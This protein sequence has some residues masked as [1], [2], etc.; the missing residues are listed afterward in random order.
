[1]SLS[2]QKFVRRTIEHGELLNRGTS[3]TAGFYAVFA[4]F[5]DADGCVWLVADAFV[6][7]RTGAGRRAVHCDRGK[8]QAEEVRY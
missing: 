4:V 3:T 1:M 8:A 6:A 2:V 5:V 7:M